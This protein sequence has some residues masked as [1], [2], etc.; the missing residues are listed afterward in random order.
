MSLSN[1]SEVSDSLS[2][3]SEVSGSLINSS[4]VIDNLGNCLT[5]QYSATAANE[6]MHMQF[7][8]NKTSVSNWCTDLH[9]ASLEQRAH[10]WVL[11]APGDQWLALQPC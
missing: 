1:S 3:S 7:Y 10:H 6:N 4:E 8:E 11:L 2:N 9:R 5:V